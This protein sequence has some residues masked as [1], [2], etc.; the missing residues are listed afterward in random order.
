[1][2]KNGNKKAKNIIIIAKK[3][4]Q[5]QTL[6]R[7]FK[8]FKLSS[9]KNGKI[10]AWVKMVTP[11][12]RYKLEKTYSNWKIYFKTKDKVSIANS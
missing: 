12:V 10:T 1:M 4:L 2:N 7:G 8:I 9:N 5:L 11:I 6:E 3:K